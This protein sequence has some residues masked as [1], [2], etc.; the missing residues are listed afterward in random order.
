MSAENDAAPLP[1]AW[2]LYFHDDYDADDR[3]RMLVA[4]LVSFFATPQGARFFALNRCVRAVG[5][6]SGQA[7]A[8]VAFSVDYDDFAAA[9]GSADLV[10][11]LEVQPVEGLA[12]LAAAAHEVKREVDEE[13]RRE[14]VIQFFRMRYSV[15]SRPLPGPRRTPHEFEARAKKRENA[16][17]SKN[18]DFDDIK[19]RIT[20][21][22]IKGREEQKIDD[23]DE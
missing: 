16:E 6:G 20:E 7:G 9:C 2:P 10:A 19:A 3:R 13:G 8:D 14:K 17:L 1:N 21:R 23:D 11:S 4:E 15:A 18:R 12:C 5:G 22:G